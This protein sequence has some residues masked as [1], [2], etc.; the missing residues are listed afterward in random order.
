M[1]SPQSEAATPTQFPCKSCG[2]NLVFAPGTRSLTCPYCGTPN[3]IAPP[4][5]MVRENDFVAELRRLEEEAPHAEQL[6]VKCTGCGAESTLGPNQT[7]G[8]CPFCGRAM[9]AQA[10]SRRL[11]K[12]QSLLPF[13]VSAE[14]A[15]QLFRTWIESLWFAPGDL[16]TFAERGGLKGIYTPA[17]TYDCDTVTH[18]T[19]QR[20]DDYWVTESY[21]TTV[22]GRSVRQTRQ[23][24][25]TRW[26]SVS[27]RV[28][29]R[30]DD[31]LVMGSKSLPEDIL[32]ELQ[33]WDLKSLVPYRDEY[34]AGFVAESYQVDLGQGFEGAKEIM[35]DEIASHIRSDIGGDH[36]RISSS[37]TRYFGITYKHILLPV[38]LS[39]YRYKDRLFQFL[40]NARTGEVK[41]QR[42]YSFWK[43]FFLVV[44]ILAAIA[45]GIL[46]AQSR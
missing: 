32:V 27:G 8:T 13:H 14:R 24:R 2:A 12:P 25:K 23:V 34:L 9:V 37:D 28:D 40:V 10:N 6:S 35:A 33:P 18:Y 4:E 38:W 17:W 7:A 36:Q 42:P 26:R 15:G 21:T 1:S 41:G 29:D 11:I 46:I 16:K 3:E 20:G 30:F 19:G 22:N 45:V 31:V 44:A 39:S 5:G 43:I